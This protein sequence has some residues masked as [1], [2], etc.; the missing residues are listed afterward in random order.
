MTDTKAGATK[1]CN[2]SDSLAHLYSGNATE[3]DAWKIEQCL[4]SDPQ[5]KENMMA[6]AELLADIEDLADDPDILAIANDTPKHQQVIANTNRFRFFSSLAAT[7]FVVTVGLTAYFITKEPLE[8]TA[9][10]QIYRTEA[11]EQKSVT[12]EDGSVLTLNTS[13]KLY[14]NYDE[15]SRHITLQRGE[16]FFDVQKDPL[17]P[18]SIDL[19]EHAVTVLGTEFNVYRQPGR[20]QVSVVEGVVAFH[21]AEAT[22][23][24]DSPSLAEGVRADSAQSNVYVKKPGQRRITAGWVAEYDIAK[25]SMSGHVPEKMDELL[26]WRTGMIEFHKQ[27]L[28]EVVKTLNRYTEKKILIEDP[29]V[30]NVKVYAAV[31]ISE[32]HAALGALD[33]MLPISITQHSDKIVIE[34]EPLE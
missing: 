5:F 32:I 7:F 23:Q 3:L 21:Q 11:G 18:F 8:H 2:V 20:Y 4:E 15:K 1:P 16:V 12:L 27:P 25:N 6:T 30:M 13:S 34:G 28:Y 10:L 19:G 31:N 24:Q 22:V 9:P 26:Q 14:V 29:T 17:R 33:Q